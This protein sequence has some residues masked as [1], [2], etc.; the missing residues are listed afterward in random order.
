MAS[1]SNMTIDWFDP[2]WD[3]VAHNA[4]MVARIARQGGCRGI[5]LDPEECG[6][7]NFGFCRKRTPEERGGHTFEQ[8]RS[9]APRCA[10]MAGTSSGR[11]IGNAQTSPF[12]ASWAPASPR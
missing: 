3:A 1:G 5:M 11:S 6:G 4:Q 12:S 2:G 10:S 8:Y 7:S 9:T